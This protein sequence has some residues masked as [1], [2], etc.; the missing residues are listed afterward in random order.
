MKQ[1]WWRRLLQSL[2]TLIRGP[3]QEKVVETSSTPPMDAETL[4][5]LVEMIF[6]THSDEMSCDDCFEQ[7]DLFAELEL[8]GEDAA[9]AMPLVKD[10]LERCRCCQEEYVALMKALEAIS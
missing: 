8:A 2:S 9:A 7:V 3:R 10:H 1:S 5:G 4:Q 6:S